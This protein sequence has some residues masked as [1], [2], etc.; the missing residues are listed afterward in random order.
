MTLWVYR[1]LSRNVDTQRD[2][3]GHIKYIKQGNQ[4]LLFRLDGTCNSMVE[5]FNSTGRDFDSTIKFNA[6]V[7]EECCEWFVCGTK[8]ASK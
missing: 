1:K 5:L 4:N 8:V 3:K 7:G 2:I 6:P